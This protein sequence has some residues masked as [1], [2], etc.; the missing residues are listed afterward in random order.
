V[1]DGDPLAAV[2]DWNTEAAA[3]YRTAAGQTA[4]SGRTE[5]VFPWASVTKVVTALAVWVAVEEGITA[6]DEPAG[7]AGSTV[8]HLL[9]H[10]SGL[11][12]DT[13]DVLAPP[14]RRRIYS[15]RGI[16]VVAAHVADRARF[17]FA[18]YATEAVLE[19]L[20]MRTAS[21]GPSPARDAGG[22]LQDLMALAAELQ[23]PTLVAASTLAEATSPAFPGLSGVLPGFGS[24]PDNAWG[25]GVEIRDHK[26]PH[27]TGTGNSAR[28]FGHF[29]QSGSFLWVDPDAG[30]AAASLAAR[31][32]GPWATEAWPALSDAIL[33]A[34]ARSGPRTPPPA[35]P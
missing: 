30:V 8:R 21:M 18:D 27:W 33:D 15:N 28:T 26:Q 24:Q 3:A 10:A 22:S 23:T 25:L 20:R 11:A 34:V 1:N 32:F 14:G 35:A 17:A 5:E 13:D 29:G 7:P 4:M 31:S 2:D 12:P 16:E 19:P 6:W 9:A